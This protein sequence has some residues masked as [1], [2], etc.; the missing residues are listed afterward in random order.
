MR[1]QMYGKNIINL[2]INEKV[3]KDRNAILSNNIIK[4]F[5][6]G[7]ERYIK[8]NTIVLPKA[9]GNFKKVYKEE[10]KERKKVNL[11]SLKPI[12]TEIEIEEYRKLYI[13]N[14]GL[15]IYYLL[16]KINCGF[17]ENVEKKLD[18]I[19]NIYTNRIENNDS[20]KKTI[21]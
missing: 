8:K 21:K 14:E 16:K 1:C 6:T 2:D 12:L 17:E 3:I 7:N 13:I 20:Y 9:N 11:D 19:L 18:Y 4:F 15:S 10:I 5:K